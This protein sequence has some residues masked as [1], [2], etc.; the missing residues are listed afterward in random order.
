MYASEHG[1]TQSQCCIKNPGVHPMFI[2]SR[3]YSCILLVE[4]I[5]YELD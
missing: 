3:V 4:M 5:V 2:E 1:C